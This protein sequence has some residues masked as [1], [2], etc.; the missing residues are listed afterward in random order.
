MVLRLVSCLVF[1]VCLA[2]LP[3]LAQ[4]RDPFNPAPKG[5]E[6]YSWPDSHGNWNF[7]LRPHTNSEATVEQVQSKNAQVHGVDQI[8]RRI[9]KLPP[10]A[11][12]YWLD[13]IPTGSGPRAKGS[14]A[15]AFP[16]PEVREEIRQFAEKRHIKIEVASRL[17]L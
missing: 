17:Y 15:L 14:E 8:D 10:Q 13:R 3:S 5:Y 1:L 12:I 6:L 4:A 7:S 9:S 2:G 11:R 16:P